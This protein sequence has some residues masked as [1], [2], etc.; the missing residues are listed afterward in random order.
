MRIRHI[1]RD[2]VIRTDI[3]GHVVRMSE[4]KTVYN[5]MDRINRREGAIK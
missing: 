1:T 4:A 5:L 2:G 3:T